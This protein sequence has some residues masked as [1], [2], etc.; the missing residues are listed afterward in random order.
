MHYRTS[1]LHVTPLLEGAFGFIDGLNLLVHTSSDPLIENATYNGW[2][3]AHFV[4]SVLFFSL[5]GILTISRSLNTITDYALGIIIKCRLNT[6][7]SW[8]NAKIAQGIFE[9]LQTE[10][11]DGYYI[12]ADMAFPCSARSIKGKIKG[13]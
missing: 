9:K 1:L 3:H 12:V 7:G 2:L 6:P 8:H 11:L 5:K 10:I 13:Q 4:S